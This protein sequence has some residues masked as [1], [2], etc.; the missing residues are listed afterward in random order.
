MDAAAAAG[1]GVSSLE[2]STSLPELLTVWLE[3]Q[4]R[5]LHPSDEGKKEHH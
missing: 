2:N 5:L 1:V 4:S 3:P